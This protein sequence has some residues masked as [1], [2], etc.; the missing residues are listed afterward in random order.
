MLVPR[1][2]IGLL[3]VAFCVMGGNAYGE[4]PPLRDAPVVWYEDD[5]NDV[6]EPAE[7]DPN[8]T[9][10]YF[11]GSWAQPRERLTDPVRITWKIGT[12]FGGQQVPPADNVNALDEVPNSSWFTNR[13]GL[14]AMSPERVA[15]GLGNGNGPDR[16]SPWTI[17]RAKGEGVSPGFTIEDAKGDRYLI[18][19][20]PHGYLYQTTAAGVISGRI[21][22]AAGYN[23]PDDG[24]VT[25]RREDLVLAEGV[26][27]TLLTGKKRLMTEADVDTILSRVD[28]VATDE[29]RALCSKILDGKKIGPFKYRGRRKDDPNDHV[30]HENRRELRGL[31]V[32]AAWLNHFDTK[33]Q[34]TLDMYVSENGKSF[35]KHH[36]LDFAST[37]G[38]SAQGLNPRYGYEYAFDPKAILGRTFTLG[39][40]EDRWRRRVRPDYAEVGYWDDAVFEASKFRP[41]IPN[42]AFANVTDRDGYWGAKIA[43]AFSDEHIRAIV[44][45]GKYHE[46]GAAE[47]VSKILIQKR[48]IVV[49][50]FFDRVA[51]LDF[52][53][54]TDDEVRFRDLGEQYGVYPNTQPR[55]RVRCAAVDEDRKPEGKSKT[56]WAALDPTAVP[57]DSGPAREALDAS[58]VARRPFLKL[59]FQ[60]NRGT[61]WSSSVTA[62]MGR[63]SGQIVAVDR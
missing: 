26:K 46:P 7:R 35:V 2:L 30:K 17:V 53:V 52:F 42:D 44:A 62:Y 28:H 51:P 32:F 10:D 43:G 50:Y 57:L 13:I 38:A 4:R 60:V 16:S 54:A 39:L 34:N 55:Y 19:F 15:R 45:Q 58:D 11:D 59:E 27:M 21:F 29:W 41:T 61:G 24:V 25:F 48:D 3:L 9:L 23:V 8:I 33:Q 31:Y 20:D 14:F 63:R 47:Y 36:L 12:L 5:R 22:H 37:L 1:L 40:K 56:K 6:A 49:R 18:K